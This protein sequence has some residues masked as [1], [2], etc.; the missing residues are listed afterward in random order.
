[1]SKKPHPI[2]TTTMDWILLSL[3]AISFITFI[4]IQKVWQTAPDWI[5]LITTSLLII[6]VVKVIIRI[7]KFSE[8]SCEK[9]ANLE[10]SKL[11]N[12]IKK[13]NFR[14]VSFLEWSRL[15]LV[16]FY[17]FFAITLFLTGGFLLFAAF[18]ASPSIIGRIIIIEIG[19]AFIITAI[20]MVEI[21]NNSSI[22]EYLH[23]YYLKAMEQEKEEEAYE[24]YMAEF[25][26]SLNSMQEEDTFSDNKDLHNSIRFLRVYL[27]Y[28]LTLPD[29]SLSKKKE[30]MKEVEM[31]L[32]GKRNFNA[33][34]AIAKIDKM[35]T[36]HYPES[37]KTLIDYLRTTNKVKGDFDVFSFC[38]EESRSWGSKTQ[39][40]LGTHIARF[41]SNPQ[42]YVIGVGSIIVLL[43]L[44]GVLPTEPIEKLS[45][46][47][48][49]VFGN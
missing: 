40:I 47:I 49:K 48:T 7:R 38:H 5:L 19:L 24:Q 26:Q 46:I 33:I 8:A 2:E 42:P 28:F 37:K 45:G 12:Y 41:F 17:V 11:S 6:F 39:G 27:R 34:H 3:A 29:I 15:G 30:M 44:T 14:K 13:R 16:M 1:V 31:V 43:L 32:K 4:I 9:V 10:Y 21:S 23:L 36:E 25:I 20:N 18:G 35:I 22:S